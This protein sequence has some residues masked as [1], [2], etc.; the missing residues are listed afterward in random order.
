VKDLPVYSYFIDQIVLTQLSVLHRDQDVD[1]ASRP[2]S[3]RHNHHHLVIVALK[4][5]RSKMNEAILL[6]NNAVLYLQMGNSFE[7]C[8]FLTEASRICL[9]IMERAEKRQ[10]MKHRD[11]VIT[12]V[13][14]SS[15]ST[16]MKR[17]DSDCPPTMYH[18]A[19]TIRTTCCQQENACQSKRCSQC[20]D[21]EYICPCSI[22]PIVWYNLALCC[23]LLGAELGGGTSDGA[24]YYMRSTYLYEKVLNIYSN[25]KHSQGLST[26]LMAVLNN[27]A[28]IHYEL[29]RL[30]EFACLMHRMQQSLRAV[31]RPANPRNWGVFHM[32]MI[33]MD[34][35]RPRPA[36]AA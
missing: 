31:S 10:R 13:N 5:N 20:E 2:T 25:E 8:N 28:C 22:A 3:R 35:E 17:E 27:Q 4:Q 14:F 12:W 18:Y 16:D 7:A 19:A 9:D 23:Q 36:A 26:L 29:G 32:N 1:L 11:H 34:S 6:N 15:S 33:M 30:S 24:F 21:D